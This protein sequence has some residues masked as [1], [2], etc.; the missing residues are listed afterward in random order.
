MTTAPQDPVSIGIVQ[1]ATANLASV[2][3][4]LRR[5]G[6][7][8]TFLED[9][10]DVLA[11]PKVVLPGVG[12]FGAAMGQ[13]RKA[14]LVDPLRERIQRG[15][16]TLGICL[17][18]QLLCDAS[19]ESPGVEGLG[20][21]SATVKRFQ[22]DLRVP[23]FGWSQVSPGSEASFFREGYAYFAN[24]YRIDVAPAIDAGWEVATA[25]Y[26]G[27]YVAAL[28]K[29]DVVACQCHP[30]LSGTWGHDLLT[31]WCNAPQQEGA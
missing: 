26:G 9:P 4:G 23:Q 28:R 24:S 30:E 15:L 19:E 27:P 25:E 31:R 2:L 20:L 29:G 22:G 17:G 11:F 12:A 16:P 13:L 1:T 5:A 18:L 3:A 8:P 14:G 21:I 10:A 6:A 7:A